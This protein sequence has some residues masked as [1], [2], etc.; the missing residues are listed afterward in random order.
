[1]VNF[2]LKTNNCLER[3]NHIM[4]LFGD[5]HLL[6]SIFVSKLGLTNKKINN[7]NKIENNKLSSKNKSKSKIIVKQNQI[8]IKIIKI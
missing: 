7:D 3:L 2:A 6:L 8:L 4:K 1:M 5:T